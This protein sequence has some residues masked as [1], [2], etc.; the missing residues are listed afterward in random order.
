ML[1]DGDTKDVCAVTMSG[2]RNNNKREG[3]SR[4]DKDE[5]ADRLQSSHDNDQ[6]KSDIFR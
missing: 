3:R 6:H 5:E 1:S 4:K 2:E